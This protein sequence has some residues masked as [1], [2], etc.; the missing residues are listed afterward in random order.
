MFVGPSPVL[1]IEING[2][3][4]ST[5]TFPAIAAGGT[6]S[7]SIQIRSAGQGDLEVRLVDFSR[8]DEGPA[9]V[10][11]MPS[12]ETPFTLASG[13]TRSIELIYSPVAGG[14]AAAGTLTVDSNDTIAGPQTV[15]IRTQVRT[16]SIRVEPANL[17]WSGVSVMDAAP[18]CGQAGPDLVKRFDVINNGQDFLQITEYRLEPAARQDSFTVCPAPF[19]GERNVIP[20]GASR[21]WRAVFH[22]QV[23]GELTAFLK[24][25]TATGQEAQV[26]LR[27]ETAGA[28]GVEVSPLVLGW[29]NLGLDQCGER[30]LQI[31]N[32]GQVPLSIPQIRMLPNGVEDFYTL[33]GELYDRNERRLREA[34]RGGECTNLVVL[35]CASE[36]IVEGVI[37]LH[38][39]AA[40]R[41]PSPIVVELRGQGR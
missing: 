26:T 38:H 28:G 25:L 3:H 41:V 14:V 12:V 30:V 5:L 31:C 40:P 2:S 34:L 18:G 8:T 24:I 13:A 22:P 9:D 32:T 15:A 11:T 4:A 29:P 17:S 39:T 10:L 16:G 6:Y 21:E 33:S 35:Y 20:A 1:A 7:A 36:D 23:A 27:G 37:E 19:E